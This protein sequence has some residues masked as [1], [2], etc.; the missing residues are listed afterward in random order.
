MA[1]NADNP[2]RLHGRSP[3]LYDALRLAGIIHEGD[4]VRRVIIDI[5]V[6]DAVIVYIERYGDS[7]LLDLVIPVLASAEIRWTDK[8]PETV[9]E[10]EAI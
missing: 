5:N 1:G 4:H 10:A 8:I 9:A 7:R 2:H 6:S 3:E